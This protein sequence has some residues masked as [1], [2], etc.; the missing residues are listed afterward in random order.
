M[1][2]DLLRERIY[3]TADI[4]EKNGKPKFLGFLSPEQAVFADR[5]LEN[6]GVKYGFFGGYDGADRVMLGC[7][8]DWSDEGDYPVASVTVSYRKTDSLSHRDFL[9]TLMGLGL[10]R[11]AVGDILTEA[12]RAVF[13][14]TEETLKYI[15]TQVEKVGRV[16]VS[17]E[18]GFVLPLPAAGALKEFSVTVSSE[19][20]DC[21]VA[22]VTGLSRNAAAEKIEQSMV[23]V[24][25]CVTEKTTRRVSAGDI[26]SVR[27]KGKF[28][29]DSIDG[30][31]RKNK[32]VLKYKKYV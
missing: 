30:K 11:E 32:I 21:V 17:V 5:L 7:F 2:N 18:E 14:V 27:S 4:C 29:I 22:A 28:I 24:N 16:G 15:L 19:R 23:S 9:G 12:G 31:T 8:P 6:R 10:K 3:D 25:S 13:F 1:D 20:L 26:V